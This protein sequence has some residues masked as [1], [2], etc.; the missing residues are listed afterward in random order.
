MRSRATLLL[1]NFVLALLAGVFLHPF[2]EHAPH[3]CQGVGHVDTPA[4]H[5][6]D[7][8]ACAYCHLAEHLAQAALSTPSQLDIGTQPIARLPAPRELPIESPTSFP[9]LSR[10]PPQV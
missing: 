6:H 7:E 2:G 9:Y 3:D 5:A 1:I 4:D 8:D 10:G